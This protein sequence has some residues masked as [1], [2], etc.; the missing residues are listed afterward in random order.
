[1][2]LTAWGVVCTLLIIILS[3]QEGAAA[4]ADTMAYPTRLFVIKWDH[5]PYG[6]CKRLFGWQKDHWHGRTAPGMEVDVEDDIA[7]VTSPV[8][9]RLFWM[10]CAEEKWLTESINLIPSSFFTYIRTREGSNAA[11]TKSFA[12]DLKFHFVRFQHLT[13]NEYC[14]MRPGQSSK[15]LVKCWPE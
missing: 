8:T 15:S 1:M 12:V 4:I 5:L 2:Y 10:S 13:L 14:T 9:N 6:E 11:H 7:A 3:V